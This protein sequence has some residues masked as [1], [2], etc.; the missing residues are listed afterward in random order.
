MVIYHYAGIISRILVNPNFIYNIYNIE[1]Y[2]P[3]KPVNIHTQSLINIT[4]E[5]NLVINTKKG[6]G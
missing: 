1:K 6:K 5:N 2:Y 3:G 4:Q